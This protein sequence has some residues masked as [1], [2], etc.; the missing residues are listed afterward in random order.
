LTV[1]KQVFYKNVASPVDR[2]YTPNLGNYPAAIAQSISF[3]PN[4]AIIGA[5]GTQDGNFIYSLGF[6][7]DSRRIPGS[8]AYGSWSRGS[9]FII[10]TPIYSFFGALT[11]TSGDPNNMGLSAIG[12]WTDAPPPPPAPPAAPPRPPIPPALAVPP[13]PNLGRVKAAPVGDM[14]G[15]YK[16]DDGSTF[17]G[18]LLCIQID[19][20]HI[21]S[22]NSLETFRRFL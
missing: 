18:Q 22:L 19:G 6:T 12:F 2:G 1:A 13:P 10:P 14:N 11:G 8:G 16:W 20:S 7:T 5:F 3:G 21:E 9:V 4:E 17:T 15:D